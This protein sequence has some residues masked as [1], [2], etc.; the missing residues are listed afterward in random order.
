MNCELVDANEK[1]SKRSELAKALKGVGLTLRPDFDRQNKGHILE[2]MG[3][4]TPYG[5]DGGPLNERP[6]LTQILKL[7]SEYTEVQLDP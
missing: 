4:L 6:A 2:V 7:L 3:Q 5:C 1:N